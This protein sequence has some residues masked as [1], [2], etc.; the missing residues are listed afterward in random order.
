MSPPR[1]TSFDQRKVCYETLH[2]ILPDHFRSF[3]GAGQIRGNCRVLDCGC[4]YGSVT[5]EILEATAPDRTR[6]ETTLTIDLIDESFVQL[7]KAKHELAS[8]NESA[9]AKLAF[10]LGVFPDDLPAGPD[11]YDVIACKMVLHEVPKERQATFVR[12]VYDHLKVKGRFIFWDLCLPS[13]LAS[14][15]RAVF[16]KKDAL[17]DYETLVERRNFMTEPEF[18]ELFRASPFGN[19]Q[20]V[21][22]IA[23]RFDTQKR[24]EAELQGDRKKFAEWQD[25]I[26]ASVAELDP[27]A[28]AKLKF[29]DDG[30]SISFNVRKI[31]AVTQRCSARSTSSATAT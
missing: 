24:L 2:E 11:T 16:K 18:V 4:G 7:E 20:I 31:I 9:G 28:V 3:V 25:F 5:R 1:H 12:S 10:I 6:G 21:T 29:E 26:R 17:A 30:D 14:F 27:S 19:F 13:D 22:E 8:W 23:Y 15:Y